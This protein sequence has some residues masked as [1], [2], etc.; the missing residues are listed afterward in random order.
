MSHICPD[1][2]RQFLHSYWFCYLK[3]NILKVQSNWHRRPRPHACRLSSRVIG[4]THVSAKY[5]PPT[6]AN[7]HTGRQHVAACCW[8]RRVA[9][10]ARDARARPALRRL[11]AGWHRPSWVTTGP[12]AL[13]RQRPHREATCVLDIGAFGISSCRQ[14]KKRLFHRLWQI[15]WL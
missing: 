7:T 4:G 3:T 11:F 8:P 14:T 13:L 9:R 5:A 15:H 6:D 12:G 2:C 1:D 10:T